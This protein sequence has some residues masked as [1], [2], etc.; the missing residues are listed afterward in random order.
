MERS[1]EETREDVPTG[2]GRSRW[3][4]WR[5]AVQWAV[6]LGAA[7]LVV[8]VFTPL[9]SWLGWDLVIQDPP[10]KADYIVVLGG[11]DERAVEAARLYRDGWAPKVIVSTLAE[12]VDHLAG[13][14]VR[15]GVAEQAV[16][17][18]GKTVRTATHPRTIA[19]LPGVRP[20][21]DRFLLVTS[22][23]HTSRAKACFLRAGYRHVTVRAPEWKMQR[24]IPANQGWKVRTRTLERKLYEYLGWAYYSLRGWV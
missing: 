10:A 22:P 6:N 3:R 21:R 14:A 18:D 13:V 12:T 8:L 4:R 2:G 5:R 17:R 16:L 7:A 1:V 20:E 19:A 23:Y 11:D 9:G 24:T 15:Y